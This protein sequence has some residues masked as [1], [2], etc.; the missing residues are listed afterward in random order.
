M[1][2]EGLAKVR[3]RIISGDLEAVTSH[4]QDRKVPSSGHVHA[5]NGEGGPPQ[6]IRARRL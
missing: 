1:G 4:A 5:G 2:A 3:L 6:Q